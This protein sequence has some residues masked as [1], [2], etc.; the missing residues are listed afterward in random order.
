MNLSRIIPALMAA[1]LLPAPVL[2]VGSVTDGGVTFA[3][4]SF[5]SG[6]PAGTAN[7]DFTIGG[8]SDHIWESWWYFEI[9]GGVETPFSNAPDSESYLGNYGIVSWNDIDGSGALAADLEVAVFDPGGGGGQLFQELTIRNV[10]STSVT[11]DIFHYSDFDAGGSAGGESATLTSSGPDIEMAI[12]DGATLDNVP[13]VGYGADNFQVTT[14]A[15]LL[16]QLNNGTSED[17]DD[18]GLAFTNGDFT[19][20]FEWISETLAPGEERT[21]LT[22]FGYNAPLL[23]PTA[24]PTP[25][26]GTGI[27]MGLGLI[28][29]AYQARRARLMRDRTRVQSPGPPAR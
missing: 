10:T 4:T 21:F 27:L 5:N 3:W 16:N 9:T 20:A 7:A 12:S 28:G 25:E 14:Y 18:S 19:G 8:G 6:G 1:V 13:W 24:M 22:Q 29:L 2:A 23:S 11:F 17:L 26:P 15:A